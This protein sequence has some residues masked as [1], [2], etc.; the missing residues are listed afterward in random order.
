M[1]CHVVN[2]IT[3][4]NGFSS[5]RMHEVD[6]VTGCIQLS[7]LRLLTYLHLFDIYFSV[8]QAVFI[9]KLR[10]IAFVIADESPSIMNAM[11]RSL[12]VNYGSVY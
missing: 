9:D 1:I 5:R 6:R 11:L 4:C 8:L 12:S 10:H 2:S 7:Y 3:D